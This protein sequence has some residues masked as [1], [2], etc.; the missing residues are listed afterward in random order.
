M[1]FTVDYIIAKVNSIYISK[2]L[3]LKQ[4]AQGSRMQ[5]LP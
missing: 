5:T 1:R 3:L 4:L 2:K